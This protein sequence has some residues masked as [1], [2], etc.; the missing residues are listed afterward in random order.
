MKNWLLSIGL[1]FIWLAAGRLGKDILQWMDDA[2]KHGLSGKAAFEYV[3]RKT[4][5]N[6]SDIGD[7]LLNLLIEVSFGKKSSLA[8]ELQR[9]LKWPD[10]LN[11]R[12]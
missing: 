7:W 10:K 12:L 4:R 8:G 11:I 3:W 6:Y 9:K 1:T 5:T 2:E